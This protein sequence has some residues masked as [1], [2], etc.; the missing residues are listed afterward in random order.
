MRLLQVIGLV[1]LIYITIVLGTALVSYI[2][3]GKA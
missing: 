2:T 1:L 3:T